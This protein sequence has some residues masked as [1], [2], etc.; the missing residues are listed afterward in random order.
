MNALAGRTVIVTRSA[1]HA[2][3]MREIVESFGATA[4]IVPLIEFV[5]EPGAAAQ[6]SSLDLEAFDWV[7]VTSPN[8]AQ[9]VSPLISAESSRP[10]IA[11]VGASTAAVL[12]RC[13]LVAET[14]SAKG[15]LERFPNGPG[16]VLVVQA[17][18]AEPT[19]ADGLGKLG[20]D[21]EV[22][23]PY[24]TVTATPSAGVRS[25]VAGADAVLFASGSAARA[26]VKIFGKNAPPIMV[27]IGEQTAAAAE[28]AGLKIS[29]ISADHSVHGMLVSL[30][31]YLADRN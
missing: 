24:R 8:G 6:L 30:R 19:M 17:V 27:A 16:R 21:V 28:R 1:D 14:Q 2:D 7:V 12:A 9:R 15:L 23:S 22:I 13:D 4:V 31:S 25:K 10:R 5:D 18:D 11:A 20:W 29:V 3:E 26:W